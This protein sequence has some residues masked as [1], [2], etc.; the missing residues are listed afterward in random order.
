MD[1]RLRN[2]V[3]W[4]R[5]QDVHRDIASLLAPISPAIIE[6]EFDHPDR[7]DFSQD[8]WLEIRYHLRDAALAVDG[9][10]EFQS[11]AA[12]IVTHDGWLFRAGVRDWP[13]ERETDLFLWF[14]QLVEIRESITLPRGF[15]LKDAPEPETVDR[16]YA[17]FGA[18]SN[19]SGR[20]LVIESDMEVRR[21][22]IPP[23]GY[24]GFREAIVAARE[25]A[26]GV[27][28]VQEVN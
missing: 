13:E 28:R 5:T 22:Q 14:T 8:M 15:E 24:G 25:W 23:D 7:D 3:G 21:R 17:A 4:R 20:K 19:V 11:P 16:T 2:L 9:G 12:T 1:G 27:Y 10:L 26:D 18:S 6:F